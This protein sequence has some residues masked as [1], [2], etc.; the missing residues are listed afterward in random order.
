M[1]KFVRI[2]I[3]LCLSVAAVPAA[4]FGC[5]W[6]WMSHRTAQ[7]ESY[8]QEHRMVSEMRAV[9]K[10]STNDSGPA[11][12]VLLRLLPLGTDREAAIAVLRREGFGCQTIA[13]PITNTRLR[14]RFM[15]ARG[16]TSGPHDTRTRKRFVDCQME[17]PNVMAHE[18]W[19]VDLEFDADGHLTDAGIAMWN[20]FL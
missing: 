6:L 10:E 8:Y 2:A 16:S 12:E 13:E 5:L 18:H 20:I 4:L 1:R 7:V 17:T 3:L 19:I 11:R 9:Q 15:E 14:Q